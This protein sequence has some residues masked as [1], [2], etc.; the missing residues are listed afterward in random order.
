RRAWQVALLAPLALGP[1]WMLLV[2]DLNLGPAGTL[3][4]L[5]LLL[6]G[7]TCA[8]TDLR[9]RK[10]FN[11]ATYSAFLWALVLNGGATLLQV[12][13]PASPLVAAEG[14]PLGHVGLTGCLFGAGRCFFI[15]V[16]IYPMAGG[17]AG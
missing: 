15:L 10:I 12:V 4:G 2:G 3:S 8:C 7:G 9:W 1:A 16:L 14:S 6:L 11:W 13:A 5:I 17:G